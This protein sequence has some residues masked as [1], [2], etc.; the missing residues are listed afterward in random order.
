MTTFVF[1][2]NGASRDSEPTDN[3]EDGMIFFQYE[4]NIIN[5]I[6]MKNKYEEIFSNINFQIQTV[7]NNFFKYK[8]VGENQELYVESNYL[9]FESMDIIYGFEI[10]IQI[11]KNKFSYEQLELMKHEYRNIINT[12]TWAR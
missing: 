12:M 3:F 6:A 11:K 9:E 1:S 4:D 8:V 5:E 7:Y 10:C 2:P